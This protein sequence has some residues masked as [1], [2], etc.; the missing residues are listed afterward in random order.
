MMATADSTSLNDVKHAIAKAWVALWDI[1]NDI[2]W[3]VSPDTQH[4]EESIV[5]QTYLDYAQSG[6]NALHEIRDKAGIFASE[7]EFKQYTDQFIAERADN[8]EWT[9]GPDRENVRLQAFNEAVDAVSRCPEIAD[10]DPI[11]SKLKWTKT[12]YLEAATII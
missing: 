6:M 9:V 3:E 2:R 12:A 5:H 11:I 1:K 10:P 7:D 4:S 8:K